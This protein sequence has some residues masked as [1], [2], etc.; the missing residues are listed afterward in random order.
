MEVER[1]AD[2]FSVVSSDRM[3]RNGPKLHQRRFRL[4]MRKYLCTKSMVKH[5]NRLPRE[6]ADTPDCQHSRDI[7]TMPLNNLFMVSPEL[8]RQL[9]EM[10]LVGPFQHSNNI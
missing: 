8:F 5:Y 9:D 6:G 4:D 3:H 2:L 1:G 7:W 10:S